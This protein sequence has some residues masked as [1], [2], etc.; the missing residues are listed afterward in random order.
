MT[1]KG[2][3][4]SSWQDDLDL[5]A[6]SYDFIIIKATEGTGYVNPHCD[7]HY[8]QAKA[9]GKK[10]GVYHFANN[11][12]SNAVDEANYFVDNCLGYIG[13]AILVLDY[14]H[15]GNNNAA[16]VAWA[17]TWLNT[18]ANRTGVK[19]M[20]YMSES[21]VRS[22]DWSPVVAGDFGLWVAKYWDYEP[23][24]NYNM[25]T[26]GP[27][28]NISW[29]AAGYAMWQWTSTGRLNGYGGNLDTDIFYGGPEAW[30]AYAKSNKPAPVP[31][32]APTPEPA[33]EPTPAPDPIPAPVPA[34][35]P[36][37]APVPTPTPEPTPA[38]SPSPTPTPP[39]EDE[40]VRIGFFFRLLTLLFR[41]LRLEVSKK[42]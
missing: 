24:F 32:P 29:G 39:P 26:A 14:E 22:S 33:P 15:N 28:P 17:K 12:R 16:D 18:V 19:P 20:I 34:P 30:D 40:S 41:L 31:E 36:E 38:P 23:D 27:E 21:V 4:V 8:Q 5:N 6:I 37:P 25:G 9:A 11:L 35:V 7:I 13:D 1:L 42:K 3:D 10:R 2:I